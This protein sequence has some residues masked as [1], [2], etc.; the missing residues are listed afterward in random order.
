MVVKVNTK[1]KKRKLK[2]N[3]I[4]DLL[5]LKLAGGKK[6]A[7]ANVVHWLKVGNGNWQEK[8]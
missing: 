3:N 7:G 1:K 2:H 5:S 4:L 6:T 8:S